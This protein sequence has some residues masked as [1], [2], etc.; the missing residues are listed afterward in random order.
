[1]NTNAKLDTI[2]NTHR[3]LRE[4]GYMVSEC[5]VRSWVKRGL[6]PSVKCGRKNLIFYTAV[7]QMLESGILH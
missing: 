7:V 3:R 5:A 6:L 4:N 1:M 2:A